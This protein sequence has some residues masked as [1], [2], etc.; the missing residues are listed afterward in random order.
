MKIYGIHEYKMEKIKMT[1][2]DALLNNKEYTEMV[3]KLEALEA[4]RKFCRHH[5]AH[6]LDVAR[7]AYIL[8][9]ENQMNLS[10]ELIYA[11]ALIH[12]IGRVK[13]YTEGIPHDEAGAKIGRRLLMNA[14]F[15]EREA[16][17]AAGAI[18]RHRG[19][20]KRGQEIGSQ[21]AGDLL[22]EILYRADKLSRACFFCEAREECYWAEEKK[23]MTVYY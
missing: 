17:A 9:L 12:D 1:K 10:K 4:N 18:L 3:R 21:D 13:E 8:S 11:A 23:N 7:I 2:L 6:F 20:R 16:E 14:G 15:T 19:K 5:M 22:A